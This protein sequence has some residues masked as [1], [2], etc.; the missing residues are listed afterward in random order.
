MSD[1]WRI[2]LLLP[3]LFAA[4]AALA[5]SPLTEAQTR[6]M[7]AYVFDRQLQVFRDYCAGDP[8]GAQALDAGMARF[9]QAN[10]DYAAALQA[11]PTE[12]E[13]LAGVATFD[14]QFDQVAA[15]MRQQLAQQPAGP[16]C[17][18][19]GQQLGG[20][21]FQALLEEAAQRA[22]ELQAPPAT[23]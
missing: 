5:Q 1:P 12:A 22:A 3:A 17:A 13:F 2:P 19:L 9:Q 20:I 16:Q 7:G 10:P 11:R 21:S 15:Q 14:A 18:A 4:G 23:P 8:Q 6:Y